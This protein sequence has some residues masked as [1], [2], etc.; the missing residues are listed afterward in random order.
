M[1]WLSKLSDGELHPILEKHQS[2]LLLSSD[3]KKDLKVK[4]NSCHQ[5][6]HKPI[7]I[8]I[9]LFPLLLATT[10]RG[11]RGHVVKSSKCDKHMKPTAIK[12]KGID[13]Y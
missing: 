13:I 5:K 12:S 11:H 7:K 9:H 2:F 10:H 6:V 3:K 1:K 4:M 8:K